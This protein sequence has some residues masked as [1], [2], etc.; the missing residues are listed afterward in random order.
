MSLTSIP[1]PSFNTLAN[2]ATFLCATEGAFRMV[3]NNKFPVVFSDDS[4]TGRAIHQCLDISHYLLGAALV[5]SPTNQV[6]ANRKI[7][8]A[9]LFLPVPLFCKAICQRVDSKSAVYWYSDRIAQVARVSVKFGFLV[10]ALQTF[11][12]GQLGMAEL[13]GAVK[14]TGVVMASLFDSINTINYLLS[15]KRDFYLHLKWS[16]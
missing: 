12:W 3:L 14:I 2:C 4:F 1:L 16:P 5:L 7:I 13:L 11:R 6:S 10:A 9:V 8:G 15:S